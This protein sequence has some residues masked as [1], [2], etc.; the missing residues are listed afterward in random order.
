M[1]NGF[2]GGILM[3]TQRH[4]APAADSAVKADP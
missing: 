3:I 2:D 1:S 4:A